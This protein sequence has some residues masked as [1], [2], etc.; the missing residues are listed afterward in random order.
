M[1]N[2]AVVR[3]NLLDDRGLDDWFQ[4][5]WRWWRRWRALFSSSNDNLVLHL[6]SRRSFAATN[7][8]LLSLSSNQPSRRRQA[9]LT[10][11]DDHSIPLEF[12]IST[13]TLISTIDDLLLLNFSSSG[14]FSL[15]TAECDF[16]SIDFARAGSF[17][18]PTSEPDLFAI[19]FVNLSRSGTGTISMLDDDVGF[20]P[21]DLSWT[22]PGLSTPDAYVLAVNL[23]LS[24][25]SA[26]TSDDEGVFLDFTPP[27]T[28]DFLG[29]TIA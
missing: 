13:D 4:L 17:N 21:A 8:K 1:I 28:F 26:P 2:V 16:L 6:F 15:T 20:I 3:Y 29:D 12:T 7:H 27:R 19:D 11:T 18:F 10:W 9:P 25:L 14:R 24:R 5:R 22:M 23:P